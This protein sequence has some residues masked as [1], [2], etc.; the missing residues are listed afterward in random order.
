MTIM[1]FKPLAYTNLIHK[2]GGGGKIDKK[3]IMVMARD[4]NI[5]KDSLVFLE[6]KRLGRDEIQYFLILN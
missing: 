1:Y 6:L 2:G 5:D 3:I 4:R